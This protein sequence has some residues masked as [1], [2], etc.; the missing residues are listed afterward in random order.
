MRRTD[1][2]RRPLLVIL[3]FLGRR[4]DTGIHQHI[5]LVMEAA[6]GWG[7]EARFAS[8]WS[9]SRWRRRAVMTV[10][11]LLGRLDAE[12]GSVWIR[13]GFE[14]ILMVHVVGLLTRHRHRTVVLY[15]QEP[16]ATAAALAARR[17]GPSARVISTAHYNES[18]VEELVVRGRARRGGLQARLLDRRER[19][20]VRRSDLVVFPS[21]FSRETVRG[22]CGPDFVAPCEVIPHPVE[23]AVPD[24]RA[25][26]GDLISI[27]TLEPR[28]NQAFL[29]EVLVAGRRRGQRWT[30]TLVGDGPDRG[31]LERQ[32]AVLGLRDAVRFAGRVPD[33]ARWLSSH[34]LYVH[35]ARTES[36]GIVLAESLAAGVPVVAPARGAMPEVFDDGVEGRIWDLT[37]PD[38]AAETIAGILADPTTYARMQA[39]ARSRHR[40]DL[41]PERILPRWR[42]AILGSRH[43]GE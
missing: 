4:G 13:I 10:G 38:G 14:A 27:G 21:R 12:L 11:A 6:E 35:A 5:D 29:L 31:A 8:P 22:R 19:L 42:Q 41:T 23:A 15:A 28:K 24:P 17:L 20:M 33:A 30:L 26:T 25:P 40:R 16:S 1:A 37:D 7:V 9:V 36:F 32:A 39:A 43:A 2:D 18:E 34:R 3:T